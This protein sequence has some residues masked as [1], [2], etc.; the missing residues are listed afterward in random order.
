[1]VDGT[2]KNR[3]VNQ[4]HVRIREAFKKKIKIKKVIFLTLGPDPPPP[5]KW[6]KFFLFFLDTRPLFENFLKKKF[7]SPL[8]SQKHLEKFSKKDKKKLSYILVTTHK[9]CWPHTRIVGRTRALSAA[10]TRCRPHYPMTSLP[11][12]GAWCILGGG[13]PPYTWKI[14]M[15]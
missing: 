8:K 3:R 4:I 6:W 9:C 12:V 1:M 13:V 15:V 11:R 2:F 7:F 10:H 5:R 14:F